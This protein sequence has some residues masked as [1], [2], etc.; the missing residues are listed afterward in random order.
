MSEDGMIFALE[1]GFKYLSTIFQ[2]TWSNLL[3]FSVSLLIIDRNSRNLSCEYATFDLKK[4]QNNKFKNMDCKKKV[5]I[6][7]LYKYSLMMYD[8]IVHSSR[9]DLYCLHAWVDAS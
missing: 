8:C 6:K 4:R 7:A 2:R 3:L 9:T 5:S 1:L